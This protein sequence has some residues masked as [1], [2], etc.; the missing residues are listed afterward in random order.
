MILVEK[1]FTDYLLL[2]GQRMP[3]PWRK[4][5]QIATN[6]EIRERFLPQ[7]FPA[8]LYFG[9]LTQKLPYICQVGAQWRNSTWFADIIHINAGGKRIAHICYTFPLPSPPSLNCSSFSI[10]QWWMK[11]LVTYLLPSFFSA[12][13]NTKLSINYGGRRED[14][15]E[16]CN[17]VYMYWEI[18]NNI[19][20]ISFSIQCKQ[21]YAWNC[22]TYWQFQYRQ[23]LNGHAPDIQQKQLATSGYLADLQEGQKETVSED[24]RFHVSLWTQYNCTDYLCIHHMRHWLRWLLF[25][26]WGSLTEHTTEEKRKGNRVTKFL[27]VSIFN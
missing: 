25:G 12:A 24:K 10:A 8:I 6:L 17:L 23:E 11:I 22:F 9:T 18:N 1:S 13:I 27:Q 7:K 14:K 4:L 5:S 16:P 26:Q 15:Y 3:H 21:S 19:W 20:S 2:L